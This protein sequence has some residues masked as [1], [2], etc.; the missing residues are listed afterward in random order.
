[1]NSSQLTYNTMES[2]IDGAKIR[3]AVSKQ[4]PEPRC[5]LVFVNGRTE[6]IEKYPHLPSVL[7]LPQQCGFLTWDHRGQGASGGARSFVADYLDYSRD[8]N[9]LVNFVVAGRPYVILAHS[10]GSLI[11]LHG[12]LGGELTPARMVLCSPLFRLPNQPLPRYV[13]G[14]VA[15]LFCKLNFAQLATGAGKHDRKP[16][17]RNKLTH[18]IEA[19]DRIRSTPYPCGSATFGWVDA[20][21]RAASQVFEH[22]FLK[23]LQSPTLVLG[24][25]RERVVDKRSFT[26]WVQVAS[27]ASQAQ[28]GFRLIH[29]ARHELLS[30]INTY[31]DQALNAA[32]DWFKPFLEERTPG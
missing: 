10:M 5:W 7:D 18:S 24:G 25:S 6:W 12:T 9:Q 13:A 1:M 29:G 15:R 19:Y 32:K 8:A 16:F 14:P 30:E 3:Y 31:R 28:I 27:E 4:V 11:S 2:K 23:S 21:F 26:N 20:T 22:G 17:R